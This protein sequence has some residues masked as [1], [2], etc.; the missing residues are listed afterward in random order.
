MRIGNIA[1]LLLALLSLAGFAVLLLTDP[2]PPPPD[3]AHEEGPPPPIESLCGE[4]ALGGMPRVQVRGDT[5]VLVLDLDSSFYTM[6]QANLHLTRAFALSGCTLLETRQRPG[7][8]LRFTGLYPDGAP[9]R[10]ELK[11]VGSN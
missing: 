3:R 2:P 7:G 5:T 9:L 11:P 1:A 10:I 6:S 8:G 4:V